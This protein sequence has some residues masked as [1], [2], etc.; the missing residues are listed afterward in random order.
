ML[1]AG[2]HKAQNIEFVRIGDI[3]STADIDLKRMITLAEVSINVDVFRFIEVEDAE[4][5]GR[6]PNVAIVG[7]DEDH[8]APQARITSLPN[9]TLNGL[10]DS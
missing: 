3:S 9:K 5:A 8:S 2:L 10:W 6:L 7:P 4:S 1:Q